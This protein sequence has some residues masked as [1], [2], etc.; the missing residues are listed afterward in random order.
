MAFSRGAS[1]ARP[2]S[3]ARDEKQ[4]ERF[5]D[6]IAVC[7]A[8]PGCGAITVWGITDKYSFLNDRMDLQCAGSL[9]PRPL[10]WNDEH[11]K[12]PSFAGVMDA[13]LGR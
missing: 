13:L 9:P 6:I 5:H 12:K 8:R 7:V 2:R 3:A 10:L 1:G 11:Q 4:K